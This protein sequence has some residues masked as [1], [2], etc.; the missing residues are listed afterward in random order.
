M[1]KN[2]KDFMLR[3][4]TGQVDIEYD[5]GSTSGYNLA[6]VVTAIPSATGMEDQAG[7]VVT[8]GV[9]LTSGIPFLLPSSGSVEIGRAH[10]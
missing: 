6:N 2:V 9:A 3:E 5:D 4:D 7:G 8:R 1:T 10:V